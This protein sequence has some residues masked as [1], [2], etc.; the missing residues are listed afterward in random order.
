MW[1]EVLIYSNK[2]ASLCVLFAVFKVVIILA[3]ESDFHKYA[4]NS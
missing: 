1:V 2:A 3:L 4:T